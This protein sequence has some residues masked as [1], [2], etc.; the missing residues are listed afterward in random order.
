MAGEELVIYQN[1]P[2]SCVLLLSLQLNPILDANLKA[3][4]KGGVV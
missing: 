2:S 3:S 1:T 4:E